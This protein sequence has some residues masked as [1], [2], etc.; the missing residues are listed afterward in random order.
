MCLITQRFSLTLRLVRFSPKVY[1]S[2]GLTLNCTNKAVTDI[3]G[4]VVVTFLTGQC[5]VNVD[6]GKLP[7]SLFLC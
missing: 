6:M 5:S 4:S 3:A 1:N 7:V 2:T